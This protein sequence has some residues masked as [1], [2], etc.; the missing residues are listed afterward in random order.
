MPGILKSCSLFARVDIEDDPGLPACKGEIER[1]RH[2]SQKAHA[3][4]KITRLDGNPMEIPETTTATFFKPSVK[5]LDEM[6]MIRDTK[7]SR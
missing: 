3:I 7:L 4:F 1:L 2:A 6:E 5:D